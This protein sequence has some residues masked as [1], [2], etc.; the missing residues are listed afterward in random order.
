MNRRLTI[1]LLLLAV[2]VL[3]AAACHWRELDYDYIDTAQITIIYDW[4]E[5][6]L[7]TKAAEAAVRPGDAINGR[8][9]VFY[10]MDGGLPIIK[11]SHRDTVTVN[12][13]V[14]QYRAVFFNETFEDFDGI[15]FDG[16]D[17]FDDL[18]AR[19]KQDRVTRTKG[20]VDVAREPDMLAI[21]MMVPFEVTEEM[22]NFTRAMES[23]KSKGQ[24][25][26][27][28]KSEL[29]MM[30]D[31]MTVTVIP[32]SVVLP[33]KVDV[34]VLGIDDIV[35]AGAYITGFAGG[36]DFS[37][38]RAS[39]DAVT[40]RLTFSERSFFDGSDKNGTL[41]GE[42]QSFGLRKQDGRRSG[43]KFEFRAILSDGSAFE[44]TRDIDELITEA[45]EDGHLV[46]RIHIGT[47]TES[48][49]TNPPIV[50]P[51]VEPV[52]GDEGMWKVDVGGW[53][54]VTVPVDF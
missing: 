41:K 22:V 10:P 6:G 20:D 16:T 53:E 37:S 27:L 32:R 30:E 1:R 11:L 17:S 36:Y 38:R 34:V 23:R 5:S 51:D 12:L 31:A 33:V 39:E 13:N 49:G 15:R 42:F 2:T 44:E 43:Y 46:I 26:N 9:A 47:D 52:G 7:N 29:L 19:L 14:G 54:E 24:G 35:S 4:S 48:G 21:D 50:I 8:T 45:S 40:H 18:K 3:S 28:S 25:G